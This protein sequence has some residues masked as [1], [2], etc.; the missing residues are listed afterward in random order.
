LVLVGPSQTRDLAAAFP[1]DSLLEAVRLDSIARL[2]RADS[3]LQ[4]AKAARA[5]RRD[6]LMRRTSPIQGG[7]PTASFPGTGPVSPIQGGT[8][9]SP[10]PA[11]KDS[12]P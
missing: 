3:L 7:T 8:P 11:P 6:S 12:T 1:S 10:A 4:A 2:R 5:A 9:G